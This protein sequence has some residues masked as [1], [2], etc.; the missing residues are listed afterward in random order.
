MRL[1]QWLLRHLTRRRAADLPTPTAR[2]RL[3][4]RHRRTDRNSKISRWPVSGKARLLDNT[5][6]ATVYQSRSGAYPGSWNAPRNRAADR[7]DRPTFDRNHVK[8]RP[9]TSA[10]FGNQRWPTY[11]W[12]ATG[13]ARHPV[14]PLLTL[15][16]THRSGH[17]HYRGQR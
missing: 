17:R 14:A 6:P 10:T 2:H 3:L 13:T 9:A 1:V 5:G 12:N 8:V 15:A 7:P 16:A 4:A 11:A